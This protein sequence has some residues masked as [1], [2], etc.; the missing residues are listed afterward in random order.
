LTVEPL[1]AGEDRHRAEDDGHH[2]HH[3]A[4]RTHVLPLPAVRAT[5]D[6]GALNQA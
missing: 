1:L 6:A 2:D 3:H 4:F 5:E